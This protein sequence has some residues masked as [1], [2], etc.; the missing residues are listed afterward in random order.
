MSTSND[1]SKLAEKCYRLASEAKTEADRIACLELAQN[2]LEMASRRDE[3]T[4][5]QIA[6]AEKLERERKEAPEA[7][8]APVGLLRRLL[9]LFRY[10][11]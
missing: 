4:P 11:S 5:E 10:N 9:G 2:W 3:M 7:P 8:Q 6:E 1:Y